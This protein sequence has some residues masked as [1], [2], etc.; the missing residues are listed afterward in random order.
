MSLTWTKQPPSRLGQWSEG[1]MIGICTSNKGMFIMD[2]T[3]VAQPNASYA[4]TRFIYDEGGRDALLELARAFPLSLTSMGPGGCM[5]LHDVMNDV[6]LLRD[7]LSIASKNGVTPTI[8]FGPEPLLAA[9]YAIP[10]EPAVSVI[11]NAIASCGDVAVGNFGS[12]V[13][14][15]SILML[16]NG[17]PEQAARLLSFAGLVKANA[18]VYDD[19]W[20]CSPLA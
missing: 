15:A 18:N 17:F 5:I 16:V 3:D 8:P 4:R 9:A 14:T 6:D 10:S 2:G 1:S 7:L 11:V 20:Q 12:D 13:G 19:K